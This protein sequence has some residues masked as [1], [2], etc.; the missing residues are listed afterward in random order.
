M[1]ANHEKLHE[2]SIDS[3]PEI[4]KNGAST[5]YTNEAVIV[6]HSLVVLEAQ[7]PTCKNV[8]SYQDPAACLAVAEASK[9]TN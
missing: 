6:R 5:E 2:K 3:D 8:N 9:G 1:A 7:E 4:C